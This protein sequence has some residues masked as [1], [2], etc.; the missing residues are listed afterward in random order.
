MVGK[1]NH[2]ITINEL[3]SHTHN[4]RLEFGATPNPGYGP[5]CQYMQA[6]TC[7]NYPQ[8]NHGGIISTEGGNIPHNNIQP[9]LVL[10]YII[11]Y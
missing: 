9:S 10:N 7:Q 1:E 2:Q 3:P 11:K 4:I 6:T 5:P 8:I